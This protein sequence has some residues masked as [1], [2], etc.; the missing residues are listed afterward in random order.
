MEVARAARPVYKFI[1][2]LIRFSRYLPVFLL[3]AGC[4]VEPLAPIDTGEA[5]PPTALP[6]GE[7]ATVV[8]VIDGDTIDVEID[9][10]VLRVRYIGVDSPERT[11]PCYDDATNANYDLVANQ[12]VRL[13]K[14]KSETDKYDRLLRYVYV[15]DTFVN[16]V[17]VEQGWALAKEYRPDTAQADYLEALEDAAELAGRG[18]YPTGVFEGQ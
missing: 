1:M 10:K 14:D 8:K 13:V 17:L 5:D 18:C 2:S 6:G 16:A 9:G 11:D 12:T 3:L 7:L 15:G 4:V